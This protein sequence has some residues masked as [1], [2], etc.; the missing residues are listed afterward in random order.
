MD[1]VRGLLPNTVRGAL[2]SGIE[3]L[4]EGAQRL[5]PAPDI[6][7]RI[8][9]NPL[10]RDTLDPEW[11]V[12][13]GR[14]APSPEE[15]LQRQR[16]ITLEG[17]FIIAGYAPLTEDQR[18]H[19]YIPRLCLAAMI[20]DSQIEGMEASRAVYTN[21]SKFDSRNRALQDA[22]TR[23]AQAAHAGVDL[24]PI[25]PMN[26]RNHIWPA[27]LKTQLLDASRGQLRRTADEA[28]PYGLSNEMF[29]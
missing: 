11:R 27:V 6:R 5:F 9:E 1:F 20:Y 16:Y 24:S 14:P 21:I 18:K 23:R 28:P 29:K 19:I 13:A 25:D 22:M 4:P 10:E 2:R 17:N 7:R 12:R 8:R 26:L 15:I 3:S